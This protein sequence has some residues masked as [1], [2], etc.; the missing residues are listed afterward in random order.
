MGL[1]EALA[2][3]FLVKSMYQLSF[4]QT[5]KDS[6]LC[7]VALSGDDVDKFIAAVKQRYVYELLIDNLPLKLFVGETKDEKAYI[8][9]HLDFA[10]YTNNDNIVQASAVPT[11]PVELA[12]GKAINL[13]FSYAT[14]WKTVRLRSS[15]FLLPSPHPHF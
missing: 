11:S 6:P 12:P 10:V 13:R 2:G 9:T 7:E 8:Y 1:G 4:N 5:Q 15:I 3:D 14:E